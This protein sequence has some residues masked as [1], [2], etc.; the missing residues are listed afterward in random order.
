M[1]LIARTEKLW[2]SAA[3]VAAIMLLAWLV[4]LL[5]RKVLK[6]YDE[7]ESNVNAVWTRAI[8]A[9]VERPLNWSIW[10]IGLTMVVSYL[11]DGHELPLFERYFEAMRDLAV[12]LMIVWFLL[13]AVRRVEWGLLHP[14][15]GSDLDVDP[16]A[17]DAIG[18][19]SRVVVVMLAVLMA[20]PVF[21][22]SISGILAFGGVG[23]IAIGFA[24]QGLVANLFGGLT[25]YASRP[26]KVGEV[27]IMPGTAVEG[28]VEKIGWRA[29]RVLSFNRQ[30][31]YVPNSMFNTAILINYSRM[32][33]RRISEHVQVRLADAEKLPAI[34]ADVNAMLKTHGGIQNDFFVFRLDSYG[35]SALKL[36]LYAFTRSTN[37]SD[38][39]EVKEDVLL[40]IGG[41]IREHGAELAAPLTNIHMPDGLKITQLPDDEL[42]FLSQQGK[43]G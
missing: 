39:T 1:Q 11:L 15:A 40:R 35:S 42:E 30:P 12:I 18:K 4:N 13:G 25:V 8:V 32:R 10:I 43:Q 5:L 33:A 26:F 36:L 31:F 29:T 16:M 2:T 21:G 6:R 38:F 27:I 37:Y 14:P 9:A 34:I 28:T 3:V 41:I 22:F 24:A 19:L 23:G 20:M 7:R 17:V